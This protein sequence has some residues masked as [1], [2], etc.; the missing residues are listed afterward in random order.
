MSVNYAHLMIY[1][2]SFLQQSCN[3]ARTDTAQL[4]KRSHFTLSMA[5]MEQFRIANTMVLFPSFEPLF[6][7]LLM[8]HQLV[9]FLLSSL[10][11]SSLRQYV[12]SVFASLWPSCL[13]HIKLIIIVRAI[14]CSL[15][16]ELVKGLLL[17]ELGHICIV[18]WVMC[19][20]GEVAVMI[21][22]IC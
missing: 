3:F 5:F 7:Q 20:I 6:K 17:L 15:L 21:V 9:W 22:A 2:R 10:L 16:I 8:V 13:R 12:I 11:P 4:V 1:I 19:W 14:I 18:R